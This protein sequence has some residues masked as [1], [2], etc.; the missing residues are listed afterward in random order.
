[1]PPEGYDE[2]VAAFSNEVAPKSVPRDQRGKSVS[3][4]GPPEPM[5]TPRPIEGDPLTGD[6]RDGGDNPRLR[7]L[8]RDIADGRVREREDGEGSSRSRRASAEDGRS[9][10]ER[11]RADEAERDDAAADGRHSGAEDEPEDFWAIA[12]ETDDLPR[13]DE[14]GEAETRRDVAEGLPERDSETFEVTADGETFHV[15]VEEAL[16]GYSREQTFHKRLAHL[17]QVGQELQQNQGYLQQSWG[18]W[19][20]ARRDYEEDVAN[21]LPAEPNWDQLFAVDPAGAH[22]QQ[23][24]FQTIYSKLAASRQARAE[25]E[26]QA[27]QERDRQVQDY[28]VKGFSKFVLDNKIPDEPTLKKHLQSMRRTAANAGFSEYEVAT[29]Y[30]P[31]MLTVLLKASRYDRMMAARPRAVIPGKGRTLT[32]GA[33]TPL[34]G[35]GQRRGLD[36]ALRRQASSGSL[37]A[38]A[39]VFRRLL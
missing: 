26:A 28:A 10:G 14:R 39:E 31:R 7:A 36:E 33:A 19:D 30:D 17:N 22:A 5:F 32:P 38:T 20:K 12:A 29:V 21:M 9:S 3:E 8:E 27:Q 15:T 18:Q 23:K 11:R 2:A 16:R 1:M 13:S 25:R 4:S 6:T 24:I 35:N 37:D 34:N